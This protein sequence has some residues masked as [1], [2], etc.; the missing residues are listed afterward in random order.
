MA[1]RERFRGRHRH[2]LLLADREPIARFIDR[3]RTR[4]SRCKLDDP[5][6]ARIGPVGAMVQTADP[7]GCVRL[8]PA[9]GGSD[10]GTV[11]VCGFRDNLTRVRSTGFSCRSALGVV[12]GV[13]ERRVARP[14]HSVSCRPVMG[15]GV[16]R[17]RWAAGAGSPGGGQTGAPPCGFRAS[18]RNALWR[19]RGS[20]IM[21]SISES[22]IQG[23]ITRFSVDA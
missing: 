6:N 11:W 23:S 14:L 13:R 16:A 3:P 20:S 17:P 5:G 21:T 9:T 2:G 19:E 18:P 8:S 7:I 22:R 12:D 10:P 4:A 15:V 1:H